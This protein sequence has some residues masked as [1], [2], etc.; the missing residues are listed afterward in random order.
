MNKMSHSQGNDNIYEELRGYFPPEYDLTPEELE[1]E[2]ELENKKREIAL[3]MMR[4]NIATEEDKAPITEKIRLSSISA[5]HTDREIPIIR[6]PEPEEPTIEPSAFETILTKDE[7]YEDEE[8]FLPEEPIAV[9]EVE[10]EVI[11]IPLADDVTDNDLFSGYE[12]LNDLFD[13]M[14]NSAYY[15]TDEDDS[16]KDKKS[17]REKIG[18]F[19]DFLEI[20]AVCITCIIVIF[21]LFFRL[22]RVQ[23]ESMED[24]LYEN[25]YLVVSDFL[26]EPQCGD[27]VVLQ[28]TAL[29]NAQLREPLVKRIIAVGGETVSITRDGTVTVT[30]EDGTSRVLEQSYIKNEEYASA[31]GEYVV[32]EGHVFVMGDNRNHSTDSR[33]PLIG[34]V[35]ERC[36]FGKAIV[37]ILPFADFTVFENPYTT[38]KG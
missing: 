38:E 33:S 37:R 34:V 10:D 27:I 25:Q 13:E 32:P 18:W 14:E 19:F 26:Y 30:A 5:M 8:I 3:G 22:T 35:D 7:D 6:K 16:A 21:A 12:P 15:E 31:T 28:N 17:L 1:K 11:E 29:Q 24:T 4:V 9:P 20:F 2:I 36:I 23:G